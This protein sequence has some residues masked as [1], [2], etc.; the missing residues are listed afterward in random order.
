ME[1]QKKAEEQVQN[2]RGLEG[3]EG[4][5]GVVLDISKDF[6]FFFFGCI[7]TTFQNVQSR[8]K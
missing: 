5:A 6:F 4:L 1:E 7:V 8:P 3:P 2:V